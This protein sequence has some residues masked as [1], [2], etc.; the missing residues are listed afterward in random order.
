VKSS[1][2]EGSKDWSTEIKEFSR[3]FEKAGS[4]ERAEKEKSYLKSDLYFFGVPVPKIR[5]AARQFVRHQNDPDHSAVLGLTEALWAT[6]WHEL[7]SLAIAILE[8]STGELDDRDLPYLEQLLRDSRTWA[9]VDWLSVK[10]IGPHVNPQKEG[11]VLLR[12]WSKDSNMW[13]RRASMLVLLDPLNKGN[14]DFK[15]FSELASELVEE[16]EFFIRKAIGWVL[17]EVSKKQPDLSYSFLAHHIK[18]V[19]GLTLREGAKYL[20]D[21]MRSELQSLREA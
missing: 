15:L 21:Q 16:R 20:P 13:V 12:R 4:E 11:K 5:Q 8:L 6:G 2:S 7:R 17:R 19:S 18:L 14:G 1:T 9:H 3:E 10:V